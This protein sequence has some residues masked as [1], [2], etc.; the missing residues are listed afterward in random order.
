M[1]FYFQD[2]FDQALSF[3]AKN[4]IGTHPDA[5]HAKHTLNRIFQKA[6]EGLVIRRDQERL[7]SFLTE[8]A[9]HYEGEKKGCL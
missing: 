4:I 2:Q 1:K 8:L 7:D 9:K 5:E 3:T 6:I